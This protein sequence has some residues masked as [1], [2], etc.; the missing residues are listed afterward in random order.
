MGKTLSPPNTEAEEAEDRIRWTRADC[1]RLVRSGV[2]DGARYEL[3]EGDIV[4]KM[5]NRP[6]VVALALLIRWLNAVFGDLFVQVQDPM[7][8]AASDNRH[9]APEPDAAVLA[10]PVADYTDAA[11]GPGDVR[12]LVEVADAT[13]RRDTGVKARLYA[14]A[15][16]GDYWVLDVAERRLLV[17]REPDAGRYAEIVAYAENESIAP[18]TAPE[19]TVRVADLLPPSEQRAVA[20][21]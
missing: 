2:L 19:N 6:H 13:L 14:R 5:K 9:N 4:R 16:V 20:T 18:L 17:H 8:V 3:I 21:V 10:R 15:G 11:P 12:L 1:A 7:D